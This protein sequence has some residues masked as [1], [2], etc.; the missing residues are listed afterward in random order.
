MTT[1]GS[2][3]RIRNGVPTTG[4]TVYPGP[5]HGRVIFLRPSNNLAGTVA[6]YV[7]RS[8]VPAEAIYPPESLIVSTNGDGSHSFSYVFPAEFACNSDVSVLEPYVDL[9]IQEKLFYARA[10]TANRWRFSYGRKPK[11][12]RLR[13]VSL[14]SATDLPTWVASASPD[15]FDG[16]GDP[17]NPEA[18]PMPVLAGFQMMRVDQIFEV[19]YGHSLELNRLV[20]AD[21]L[22]GIPFV[23][24]RA[25][26]NGISAYVK[27]IAGLAP[28]PAGDLTVALGGNGGALSTFLQNREY[29]TGRDTGCLRPRMDLSAS[30]LLYLATCIYANRYRF[31]FGRQANRTL[32]SLM[33]PVPAD[34]AGWSRVEL[35]VDSLPF[36]SQL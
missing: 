31:G 2:L 3:F 24:R 12:D 13:A 27:P 34:S 15:Q 30:Q 7:N 20:L 9:S 6:G 21:P 26:N 32:G 36:S 25:G 35:F 4:L 17:A 33:I 18:H 8:D 14:P 29:Y 28:Y 5:A 19:I 16:E 10:I 1:L 22:S 23:S 11:G